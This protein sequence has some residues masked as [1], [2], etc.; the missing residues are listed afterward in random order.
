MPRGLYLPEVVDMSIWNPRSLT[1]EDT[2][3]GLSDPWRKTV[4]V[5]GYS[6]GNEWRLH[7]AGFIFLRLPFRYKRHQENWGCS[8]TK[9]TE[10][11]ATALHSGTSCWTGIAPPACSFE[12]LA[13]VTLTNQ[14]MVVGCS[15]SQSR[16]LLHLFH[17]QCNNI[18]W[19]NKALL[20]FKTKLLSNHRGGPW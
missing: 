1:D 12:G 13:W 6:W 2:R 17:F 9:A 15:R 19:M 10:N 7:L 14:H 11:G 4:Q 18:V 16:P 3:L 5:K 8:Q 20:Y